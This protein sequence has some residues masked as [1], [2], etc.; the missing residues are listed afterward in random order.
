M[1]V[2]TSRARAQDEVSLR[3]QNG[4]QHPRQF[5]RVVTPIPIKKDQNIGLARGAC[6]SQAG[7]AIPASWL[8]NHRGPS[9]LCNRSP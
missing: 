1:I 2:L 3:L 8:L 4:V 9:G 5:S 6:P 7:R